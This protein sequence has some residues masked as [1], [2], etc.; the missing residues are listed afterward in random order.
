VAAE[1][2]SYRRS[3]A[4]ALVIAEPAAAARRTLE[5]HLAGE[6]FVVVSG[7]DPQAR[8][9]LALV[10]DPAALERWAPQ[11]PTI[12]LGTGDADAFDRVRAFR[13]GVDDWVDPPFHYEE[14]VERIR[15]VLRRTAPEEPSALEVGSLRI[16]LRTRR[17]TLSGRRVLLSQKEYELLVQLARDPERVFTKDELL[18][19]VWGYPPDVRTRTLDSHASR[20]RRKL[21]AIDPAQCLVVNVWGIGYQLWEP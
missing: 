3:M 11:V 14:L 21:A 4:A 6:G 8:P 17:V 19:T 10:G 9:D 5:R 20:L 12:V 16:D 1:G 15:A 18:E 7:D 2:G 13:K